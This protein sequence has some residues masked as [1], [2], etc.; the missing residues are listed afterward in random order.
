MA[1]ESKPKSQSSVAAEQAAESFEPFSVFEGLALA[2]V[3]DGMVAEFCDITLGQASAWRKGREVVPMGRVVFM[4]MLLSFI[5]D[6]LV[7]TYDQWGPA[8]KSW[9]LNMKAC[10][11]KANE[12]LG[13]QEIENKGAPEGAFRQGERM[14][15][16]WLEQNAAKGWASEAANRVAL[17][18]DNTGLEI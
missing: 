3:T 15:E 5:V 2:G 7:K 14:F 9:H 16:E 12:A 1:A 10:L 4:T 6:E 13:R 17:G 18:L 8:P 11:E